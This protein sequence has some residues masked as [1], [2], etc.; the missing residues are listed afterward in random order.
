MLREINSTVV[1]IPCQMIQ[2]TAFILSIEW[3]KKV[4]KPIIILSDKIHFCKTKYLL[5]SLTRKHTVGSMLIKVEGDAPLHRPPRSLEANGLTSHG[6]PFHPPLP[7]INSHICN[8][9][10]PPF[11]KIRCSITV[12]N[13]ENQTMILS[14]P[15]CLNP[16]PNYVRR[17]MALP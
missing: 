5:S 12:V 17:V 1:S 16:D 11:W 6:F 7:W 10:S 13:R 15:E 8:I 4:R 3:L 14:S 9:N 2:R